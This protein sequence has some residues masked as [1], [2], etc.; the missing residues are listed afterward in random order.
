VQNSPKELMSLLCFLMPLFSRRGSKIDDDDTNQDGGEGMLQHFVSLE[1]GE[2]DDHTAYTK[3]KQLFSPFVLRRRKEDVLSQILPPK[4][5]KVEFVPMS[6]TARVAYDAAIAQHV[7]NKLNDTRIGAAH[8]FTQLRKAA[9][10]PLLL[11]SRYTSESEKKHLTDCF[12]KFGFFKGEGS[13]ACESRAKVHQELEKYNDFEIHVAALQ[14]IEEN[15]FREAEIGRY[16]L[17]EDDLFGAEKCVKLRS[18]LPGL[19]ADGHRM[20]VFSVWTSILDILSCL[21]EQMNINCRRMDGQSPVSER[22]SMI[23]EFN[24]DPSIKVFLLSTRACGLGINLT[25]ADTCIV[26]DIDFNPFADLQAE[27]RCHRYVQRL[28]WTRKHSNASNS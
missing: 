1:K 19:I 15:A 11:R 25:S 24:N 12:H 14:L 28:T 26:H 4:I 9:N 23:D 6:A 5:Q 20:L 16:V 2:T 17:A 22:Q 7:Q 10:H 3:L 13:I 27:D 21:M 18:L 8:L